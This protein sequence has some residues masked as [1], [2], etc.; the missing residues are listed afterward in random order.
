MLQVGE[1]KSDSWQQGKRQKS[2]KKKFKNSK[3]NDS[4]TLLHIHKNGWN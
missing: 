4:E 3:T 2:I 1:M